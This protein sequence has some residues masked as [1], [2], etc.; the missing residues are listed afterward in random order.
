MGGV[1]LATIGYERAA[2]EDFL[3]ALGSAGVRVLV[4]V[5]AVAA[6]RRKGFSKTALAASLAAAD[7]DYLH[8]QALGNPKAGRDAARAGDI[9]TYLEIYTL[10]LQSEAAEAALEEAAK[11][12]AA[13]GACLMCY[14]RDAA[15]CHRSMVA[16]E[17]RKRG[18]FEVADLTVESAQPPMSA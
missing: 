11:I 16:A 4:D 13:G 10:H 8:L 14:E 5:R 2:M 15:G 3:A 6:S 7:I 1:T 12:A 17:L 18:E 9:D